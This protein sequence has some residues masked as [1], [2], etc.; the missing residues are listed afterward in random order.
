MGGEYKQERTEE[1]AGKKKSGGRTMRISPG[2]D[3]K[4]RGK[5][6]QE[7]LRFFP[8]GNKKIGV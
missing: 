2:G 1:M 3:N 8:K 7:N 6:F 4:K 5:G